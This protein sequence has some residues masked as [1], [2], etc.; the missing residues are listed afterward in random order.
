[1]DE[2]RRFTTVAFGL[3]SVILFAGCPSTEPSGSSGHDKEAKEAVAAIAAEPSGSSGQDKGA[4]EAADA[5]AAGSLKLKEYPPLPYP[6]GHGQYVQLLR[7]RCGVECE[8]PKLPQGVDK[9]DFIQEVR[10]WNDLMR[11]EIKRKHGAD[12]FDR[13]SKE[14][15]KR[16]QEQVKTQGER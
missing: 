2:A 15:R 6:P 14:A 12:I 5:I 13:L 8:I 11:A 4:K 1:M 3:A 7:E 16:W 10:G 9:A